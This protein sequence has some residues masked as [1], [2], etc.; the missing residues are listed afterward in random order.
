MVSRRC[1]HYHQLRNPLARQSGPFICN[2]CAAFPNGHR[3]S[4][5]TYFRH[6]ARARRLN[7]RATTP[8]VASSLSD[9]AEAHLS[10]NEQLFDS[11]SINFANMLSDMDEP[12]PV[13][14]RDENGNN[15]NSDAEC[16]ESDEDGGLPE[17]RATLEVLIDTEGATR[18]ST[19]DRGQILG[20]I[21]DDRFE[22]IGLL[23]CFYVGT[24]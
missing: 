5:P 18:D 12:E 22:L 8:E 11:V 19:E 9:G 15:S 14:D 3:V 6:L 20:D 4:R 16:E 23:D 24:L 13:T 17:G 2:S 1:Y 10:D 7:N 21:W